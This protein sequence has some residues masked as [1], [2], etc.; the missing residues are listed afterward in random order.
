MSVNT[1]KSMQ[2]TFL[3]QNVARILWLLKTTCWHC[4]YLCWYKIYLCSFI[5]IRCSIGLAFHTYTIT[6]YYSTLNDSFLVYIKMFQHSLQNVANAVLKYFQ[7]FYVDYIFIWCFITNFE[8][9]VI[10]WVNEIC[11]LSF[12]SYMLNKEK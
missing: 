5:Y 7:G 9:C 12:A 1:H 10:Q 4:C 6:S 3:Y 2:L 11:F 8:Y